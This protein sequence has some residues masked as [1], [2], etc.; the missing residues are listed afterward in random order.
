[1]TTKGQ[2]ADLKREYERRTSL[3]HKQTKRA[4]VDIVRERLAQ[5]EKLPESE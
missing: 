5:E 3:L 2:N 1:M 4:I